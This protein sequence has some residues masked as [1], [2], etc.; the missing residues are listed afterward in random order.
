MTES[1]KKK[2]INYNQINRKQ[3]MSEESI[4]KRSGGEPFLEEKAPWN[5]VWLTLPQMADIHPLSLWHREQEAVQLPE[6]SSAFRNVHVLARSRFDLKKG[7]C[8]TI[9]I[10]A[11]DRYKLYLD[12]EFVQEGPAPSHPEHYYY[13]EL[14]LPYLKAGRHVLGIHLYY[15]GCVNRVFY[16]GDLRIAL[17]AE[18][19]D[20]TGTILPL[21][22]LCCRTKAYQGEL[23]GYD[24]QFLEN[25]DARRFPLGWNMKG[26]DDSGWER[27]VPAKWADY[28]LYLQPTKMLYHAMCP[29]KMV[30]ELPDGS[31]WID[32]GRELTGNLHLRAVGKAGDRIRIWCGEECQDDGNV[33]YEMRCGCTYEELWTLDDGENVWET[34]D[35]KGFRY[36]QLLADQ[37]VVLL[38]IGVFVRHYPMEEHLCRMESSEIELN[39]IFEICRHAVRLGTQESYVDC[40]T[41]EKGQYLGDALVTA[42]AQVLLTG[43]T[44]MLRKCIEQ[45]ADTVRAAPGLLAVAPGGLMQEIA[46]FSLLYPQLL[47]LYYKFT[48][49]VRIF[50]QYFDTVAGIVE[51]F[52]G[53]AREDGLLEHVSETWN[54]VDWPENLRDCYDF[55][56]TRPEVAPGCHNVINAL[57]LGAVDSLAQMAA[58]TGRTVP[59]EKELPLWKRAY[60]QVFYREDTGL[61][62]DSGTS[63][64]CALHSNVYVL[65]FGLARQEQKERML[66]FI[67]AKGFSCGVM[68]SYFVLRA[69][70]KGGRYDA[71]YRLLVNDG[72]H[73]W[74]QMLREGATTCMEAW[75]K[76]QKWNTSLC[77]PWASAPIPIILEEIA[78]IQPNPDSDKGYDFRPHIPEAVEKL[79][80]TVPFQGRLITVDYKKG[81]KPTAINSS[82]E[83]LKIED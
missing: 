60:Q 42:H 26:Y 46:D 79:H 35:Y 64:H 33:R 30:R 38:E 45:F 34:Y 25:F 52:R 59:Y 68:H 72:E 53:F 65:Y 51:Y 43:E 63:G 48:G 10:S 4:Q 23:I 22:F 12:G 37:G 74:I 75:G 56:L 2:K 7:G 1:N 29:P 39:Q 11:D 8:P 57:Y 73:G 50:E 15:Q 62:A 44:E 55:P 83:Q 41:R 27:M 40:P 54:L 67:E 47:F 3:Q 21:D 31:I 20:D 58:L 77:H 49:D 16:S 66:D 6:E 28:R 5:P 81:V 69:L 70:A 36:A 76:D 82:M 9:R 80:V 78:G 18:L 71:V 19:T 32:L 17:A 13:N 24:T 61:Y 14:R